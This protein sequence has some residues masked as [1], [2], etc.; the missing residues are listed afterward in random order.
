MRRRE[1][2]RYE[3][4]S[5]GAERVRA[6]VPVPLPPKPALVL[7][8]PLNLALEAA[9]LALGRLD[10]ISILLPDRAL[11]SRA[12][13]QKEAVLS[14]R[15]EGLRSSLSDLLL[16]EVGKTPGVP[17]DDVAEVSRCVAALEHGLRRLD[18]GFPLSSRLIREMHG[19]L[20][21]RG[22][23][24]AGA[25]GE[26]RRSQNWIGGSRPGN[27][28][29]VP[30][31]H[32]VVPDCMTALERFIHVRD[33]GL[34]TLV[35]AGLAH[36]QF[37]TIHPFL[38]GN[39]RVGRLLITLMLRDAGVLREPLL[40]L[41][42]YFKKH[43]KTYYGLLNHVRTTGDWESWLAFFLR[44]VRRTADGAVRSAGQIAR[45][46]QADRERLGKTGRR[47]GSALRLHAALKEQPILSLT[48]AAS[49]T[50]L[51]FQ[52]VSS[53]MSLLVE[54]GIAREITGRRRDRLFAYSEYLSIL[55]EGTQ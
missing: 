46:L 34:P 19:V 7:D 53:A 13:V 41:S 43:R 4:S 10:G 42:L 6:F 8:G 50:A 9:A 26:F 48:N 47:S 1:T 5:T 15:I 3:V 25:P 29:F 23:D 40:C 36:V 14:S 24:S 51:T 54:Y 37:E 39:G 17:L 35:R 12:C 18:E 22:R 45:L 16:F 21:S 27:A 38:D 52:T 49:R 28:V 11:F 44:G 20:M 33:D 31:P 32:A 30:P 55:G 2:G